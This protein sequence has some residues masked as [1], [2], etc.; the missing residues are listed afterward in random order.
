M[1]FI[2]LMGYTREELFDSPPMPGKE[3][4]FQK[5]LP[6]SKSWKK[7]GNSE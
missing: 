4:P 1:A 2:K 3:L 7:I 6:T 5:I